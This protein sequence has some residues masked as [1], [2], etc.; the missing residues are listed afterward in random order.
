MRGT[1][2]GG[3]SVRSGVGKVKYA[4]VYLGIALLSVGAWINSGIDV[5]LMIAGACLVVVGIAKELSS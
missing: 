5:G 1:G 3:K 4:L 2:I